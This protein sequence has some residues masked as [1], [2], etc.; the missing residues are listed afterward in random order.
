MKLITINIEGDNHLSRVKNFLKE[1]NA[2]VICMQEVFEDTALMLARELGLEYFFAPMLHKTAPYHKFDRDRID[3]VVGI[4]I[5]SKQPLRAISKYYKGDGDVTNEL[6]AGAKDRV[7]IIAD[8]CCKNKEKFRIATT[9]FTWTPDG[10]VTDEQHEDLK[11][12]FAILDK[13]EQED[14]GLVLC[15]DFN[16]PRGKEIFEKLATKYKDNIPLGITTTLDEDLH[17]AG[18]LPYVVDGL[19][20]TQSYVARNVKVVGGVSDHKA[21]VATIKKT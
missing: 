6:R 3:G 13:I 11:R 19:F 7:V 4:A 8:T 1:A 14:K 20:T 12:L 9:H 17:R 15:G 21:I 16:A 5:F 18:P 2:E 10:S